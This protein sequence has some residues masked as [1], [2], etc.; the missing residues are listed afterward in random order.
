MLVHYNLF[1]AHAELM[2]KLVISLEQNEF[3]WESHQD[4]LQDYF[5]QKQDTTAFII[6]F[7]SKFFVSHWFQICLCLLIAWSNA[8]N[9]CIS[10]SP[11]SYGD[12]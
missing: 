10:A 4:K 2:F 12:N 7:A 5:S 9:S 11:K 1:D 3:I 6:Y 8:L